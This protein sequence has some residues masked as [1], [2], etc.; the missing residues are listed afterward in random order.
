MN[1]LVRNRAALIPSLMPCA[2]VVHQA[3][4]RQQRG[5]AAVQGQPDDHRRAPGEAGRPRRGLLGAA[6]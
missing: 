1:F 4:R 3:A 5:S 6:R 2:A